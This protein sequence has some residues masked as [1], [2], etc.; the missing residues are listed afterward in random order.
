[1]AGSLVMVTVVDISARKRAAERLSATSAALRAS[2]DQR[3]FAMEAA[4]V[5]TWNWDAASQALTWSAS[6]RRIIGVRPDMP[7]TLAGFKA[8]V[9][10]PDWHIIEESMRRR[11]EGQDQFEIDYRVLSADNRELRWVRS[12]GRI[13]RDTSGKPIRMQGVTQDV[14]SRK[15]AERER[16]ELRRR[17]IQAQEQ[18]RLRLA[19][20]LHDQTGQSLTAALLEL[21]SIEMKANESDRN[22]IRLLRLQLNQ[23]GQMLHHVAWELRP[24]SIDEVG[25][26]EALANYVSEWSAQYRIE[27]DFHCNDTN[28]DELADYSRT[29]IYRIV[30]ESLTNI[31]KHASGATSVSVVIERHVGF[32]Q[33][34]VEDDGGGFDTAAKSAADVKRRGLGLP[35]MRERLSLIG[36]SLEIES[37]IGIGTTVFARI[38]VQLESSAA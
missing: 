27:V 2:E 4:E 11:A 15:T 14:T 29:S 33:V 6:L 31:A 38:P 35:G 23:L 30:Q 18:E 3:I 12:R 1:M 24:A 19:H 32:L 20:E 8:R 21:K 9:Y 10:P 13:D 36:G 17:Y 37:S 7:A 16:D 5:G 22:R 34:M 25:L 26:A 28:L